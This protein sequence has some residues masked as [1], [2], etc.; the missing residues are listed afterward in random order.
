VRH[1]A[2]SANPPRTYR[3]QLSVSAS[4]IWHSSRRIP[5]GIA[6]D[7]LAKNQGHIASGVLQQLLA[8]NSGLGAKLQTLHQVTERSASRL[9][10]GCAS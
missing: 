4:A 5:P 8:R 2:Q 10:R 1:P 9:G 7:L 6:L 3:D